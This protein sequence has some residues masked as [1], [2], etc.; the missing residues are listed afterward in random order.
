M[1]VNKYTAFSLGLMRRLYA[2]LFKLSDQKSD[3]KFDFQ[4]QAASDLIEEILAGP[5]PCMISRFGFY[6]LDAILNYLDVIDD[7]NFLSKSIK[8]LKSEIGPFWWDDKIA[9][10]MQN[11]AGFFPVNVANLQ[12]FAKIMLNEIR[13]IDILGSWL[14]REARLADYLPN[15]RIVKLSDLEPYYHSDPWSQVLEGKRVLV[16]HPFEESIK[17]QHAKY[18]VLFN[19]PRILPKFELKTIKTVQSIAANKTEFSNWFKALAFMCKR[20][21]SMDFDMAIIGAGAYGLPLASFVKSLGK[22]AIHLGG[23]TQLLFG[24][25]G[26]RWD[27]Y[28]F[29]R[30][31]YNENWVRP[32]PTEIPDNYQVVEG[33]CY[34]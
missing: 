16:I 10:F 34:W 14:A 32:L 17:K 3:L 22:K 31:L 27:D 15:A 11:N 26:K 23:A 6:E 9:F 21:S 19:D 25:K 20:V 33:G 1:E 12:E 8:Y 5:E 30:S 7:S 24:I 18:S 2:R 28:Q 29:F 13:N 4:G